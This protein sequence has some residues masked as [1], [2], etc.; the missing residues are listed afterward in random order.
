MLEWKGWKGWYLREGLNSSED[1][2]L[3]DPS[4]DSHHFFLLS[5]PGATD[6]YP[7]EPV[8]FQPVRIV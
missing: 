8:A 5:A 3:Q 2:I 1:K 4:E 7:D 6:T